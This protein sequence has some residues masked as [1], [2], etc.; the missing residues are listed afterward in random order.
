[1][2]K[3]ELEEALAETSH[4]N[5]FNLILALSYSSRWEL[6][7]AVKNIALDVKEG[8]LFPENISR[9]LYRNI[10]PQVNFQILN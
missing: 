6:V 2:Q 7:N 3:H 5:K 9:K 4:N 8:K 1:M 10:F